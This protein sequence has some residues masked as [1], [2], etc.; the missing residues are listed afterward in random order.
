MNERLFGDCLLLQYDR[1]LNKN[2]GYGY[3][4]FLANKKHVMIESFTSVLTEQI[5]LT[6]C[7]KFI[8]ISMKQKYNYYFKVVVLG[9]WELGKNYYFEPPHGKTN[10]LHRRKQRRRSASR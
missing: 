3:G 2:H 10:N 1:M 6:K 8:F 9:K 4:Q 7:C 5:K